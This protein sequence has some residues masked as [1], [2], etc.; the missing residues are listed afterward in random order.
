MSTPNASLVVS[1]IP[2]LHVP[3]LPPI[4]DDDLRR[5]VF[6]HVSYI[7]AP[8]TRVSFLEKGTVAGDY[9]KLEH[10]GDAILR[11]SELSHRFSECHCVLTYAQSPASR[12]FSTTC[13]R[14]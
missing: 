12:D 9:E 7:G 8:T 14:T 13:S 6:T 2:E 10:V 5:K 11:R 1:D 4:T 3:L